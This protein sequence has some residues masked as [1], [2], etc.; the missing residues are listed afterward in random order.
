MYTYLYIYKGTVFIFW[1][2]LMAW[3]NHCRLLVS[4]MGIPTTQGIHP[5]SWTGLDCTKAVAISN[6]KPLYIYGWW[7]KSCTTK[8][9]DYPIMHIIYRVLTI[10]GGAGFCPS[11]VWLHISSYCLRLTGM[12]SEDIALWGSRVYEFLHHS[13]EV[14]L[15]EAKTC[16]GDTSQPQ[17]WTY[18][19]KKKYIHANQN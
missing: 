18:K 8:D 9:D 2:W 11:T 1:G 12:F 16:Q 17:H 13:S 4:K 15:V 7:T 10:P 14:F 5:P 19:A 6:C 3:N